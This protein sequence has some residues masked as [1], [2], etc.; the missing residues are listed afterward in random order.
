M[1]KLSTFLTAILIA[2]ILTVGVFAAPFIKSP[3]SASAPE[4]IEYESESPECKARLV[5]TPYSHRDDLNND[6][7]SMIVKAYNEIRSAGDLTELNKD[8]A[9]VAQS[10]GIATRNLAVCDLFDL[11]YENCA[12]HEPHGSF[13]IKLKDD[14]ANRFVAL[15]HYYNGEWELI[16]NAKIN[17]EYLEFTI[18]EFSPFAIVV[19]NS[20]VADDTGTA[21]NPATGNIEDGIKIGVLAGVMCVSLVVGVVLWKKSKKQ[22]A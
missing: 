8:L 5:I 19:D 18:K 20:D 4:L 14:N 3:G 13:R 15:L 12:H 17:G 9:T 6:L 2:S 16:D 21:E 10:K 22:A 1:K 11:H 7:E